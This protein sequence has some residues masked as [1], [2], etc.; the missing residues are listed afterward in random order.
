[1]FFASSNIKRIKAIYDFLAP[2]SGKSEYHCITVCSL[3]VP[4]RCVVCVCIL[5]V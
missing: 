2:V 5:G 3:S 1:M 4:S